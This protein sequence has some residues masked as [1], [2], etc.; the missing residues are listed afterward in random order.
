M[1][2]FL[3]TDEEKNFILKRRELAAKRKKLRN[4][5][6]KHPVQTA[7]QPQPQAPQNGHCDPAKVHKGRITESHPLYW[8]EKEIF[9]KIGNAAHK[10]QHKLIRSLLGVPV[11]NL[12]RDRV[13]HA[14]THMDALWEQGLLPL[15]H[16]CS[17]EDFKALHGIGDDN[18]HP[19]HKKDKPDFDFPKPLK[20][21]PWDKEAYGE[22][23]P[24]EEYRNGKKYYYDYDKDCNYE[25]KSA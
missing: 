15:R 20:N 25:Y 22:A 13:Y 19:E 7:S 2:Q 3:I 12:F 8:F 24:K 18:V 10:Q 1:E 6:P 17:Y 14:L 5:A 16:K 9:A 21:R 11:Q 23:D 4:A